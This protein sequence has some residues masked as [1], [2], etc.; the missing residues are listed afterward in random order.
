[1]GIKDFNCLLSITIAIT[2][3]PRFTSF[4]HAKRKCQQANPPSYP[5]SDN[6][7]SE[8]ISFCCHFKVSASTQ[9][10]LKAYWFSFSF[11][12][13]EWQGNLIAIT[14]HECP[15]FVKKLTSEPDANIV[16]QNARMTCYKRSSNYSQ[17]SISW[18]ERLS[19]VGNNCD[20]NE[21]EISAWPFTCHR[22]WVWD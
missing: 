1:M 21:M 19:P 6:H 20:Q 9:E 3:T 17:E 18:H 13:M 14:T 16:L 5:N 2:H 11:P 8:R 22:Y 10:G 12:M 7:C 4:T 15:Q